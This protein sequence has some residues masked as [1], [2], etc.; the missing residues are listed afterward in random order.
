MGARTGERADA[1][2]GEGTSAQP[3]Q[4]AA[5]MPVPSH[6]TKSGLASGMPPRNHHLMLSSHAGGLQT[7]RSFSQSLWKLR[8]SG[9]ILIGFDFVP[10]GVWFLFSLLLWELRPPLVGLVAPAL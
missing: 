1:R 4:G 10:C 7:E 9:A 6:I 5:V 3:G 2:I 8:L